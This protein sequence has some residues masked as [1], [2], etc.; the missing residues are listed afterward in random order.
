MF[1]S[2]FMNC[3][4]SCEVYDNGREQYVEVFLV[5]HSLNKI[6]AN[7]VE[8]FAVFST[9]THTHTLTHSHS[10]G[11]THTTTTS[12]SQNNLRIEGERFLS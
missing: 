4:H 3:L 5:Q 1:V 7:F 9:H 11:I 2:V 6:K 10:T 8:K 12:T